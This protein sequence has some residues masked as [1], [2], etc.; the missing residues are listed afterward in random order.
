MATSDPVPPFG[1]TVALVAALLP[2]ATLPDT[3]ADGQRVVTKAQVHQWIN[4]TTAE[5]EIAIRGWETIREDIRDTISGRARAIVATG[6]AATTEAARTPERAGK[7]DGSYADQLRTRYR[8]DLAEL[9]A[10]VR[11]YI[12]EGSTTIGVSD[13]AGSSFP[14]PRLTD[15]MAW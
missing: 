9:V 6:A 1:A 12:S 15:H 10:A 3:A 2:D 8:E 5:V 7:A 4:D 14:P 13:T 11:D